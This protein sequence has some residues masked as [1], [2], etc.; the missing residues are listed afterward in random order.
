M[1]RSHRRRSLT[2]GAAACAGL[3]TCIHGAA[4]RDVATVWSREVRSPD[5]RWVAAAHT[6]QYGGPGTAGIVTTVA[7]RRTGGDAD[8]IV[9]VQLSQNALGGVGLAWP[10]PSRLD[11]TYREGEEVDFQA[12]R[13]AGVAIT[14][15][16]VADPQGVA[17]AAAA[18]AGGPLRP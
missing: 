15:R 12:V 6:D 8:S 18:P 17:P 5:G 10:T 1:P 3:L 11:V 13:A 4:C 2:R 14:L 9:V 16:A 7:L